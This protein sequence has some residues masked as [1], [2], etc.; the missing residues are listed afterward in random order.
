LGDGDFVQTILKEADQKLIRQI[1]LRK[2]AGPLAKI[3]KEKCR[4]AGI[5]EV[6]LRAGSQR[7]TVSKLRRELCFYLN[8]E[9]GISMAEIARQVGI[10]ATGVVMAI[11]KMTT[12]NNIE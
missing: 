11:K 1:R 3:I 5:N 6:E 10:G 9:L 7:R 2:Q 4:E 8:R 12:A